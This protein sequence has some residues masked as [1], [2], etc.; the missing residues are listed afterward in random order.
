MKRQLIGKEI[1]S[2]SYLGKEANII[3]TDALDLHMN[4]QIT[5]SYNKSS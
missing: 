5:A 2:C 3:M 1:Y 4:E